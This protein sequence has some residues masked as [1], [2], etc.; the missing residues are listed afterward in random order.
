[1]QKKNIGHFISEIMQYFIMALVFLGCSSSKPAPKQEA[2]QKPLTEVQADSIYDVV[3]VFVSPGDGIDYKAKH[4]LDEY[5]SKFKYIKFEIIPWGREGEID[6][7]I[8]FLSKNEHEREDFKNG[9]KKLFT[10]NP[11][12]VI[13]ENS[14]CRHKRL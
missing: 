11:K 2:P 13:T 7:C 14:K 1:M 5:L 8:Q 12:V 9:L 4:Q 6:Y 10:G 3:V